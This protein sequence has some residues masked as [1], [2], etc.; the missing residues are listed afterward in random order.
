MD[1][2]SFCL[3][4][5]RYLILCHVIDIHMNHMLG[6]GL[7]PGFGFNQYEAAA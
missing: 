7:Y 4:A 1:I 2:S 3:K 6:T 5:V